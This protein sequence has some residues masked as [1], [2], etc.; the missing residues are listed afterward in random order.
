VNILAFFTVYLVAALFSMSL[1]IALAHYKHRTWV[2]WGV[3]CTFFPPLVLILILLPR[4]AG[5]APF[6]V[7][8]DMDEYERRERGGFLF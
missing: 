6:E 4:R 3:M 1:A 5:P 2:L 7:E 8:S